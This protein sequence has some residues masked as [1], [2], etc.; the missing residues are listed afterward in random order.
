MTTDLTEQQLYSS[1]A[2]YHDLMRTRPP[3]ASDL[4]S[5]TVSTSFWKNHI[6]PLIDSVKDLLNRIFPP[7]HF[8]LP[9]FIP[10]VLT[11]LYYFAWGILI[12]CLVFL[13]WK[14]MG[15]LIN[16]VS[17][18]QADDRF[19]NPQAVQ[20]TLE[21]QISL[22]CKNKQFKKAMRLRWILFLE[23]CAYSFS[24]TPGELLSNI[25]KH[26]CS[27]FDPQ[28]QYQLMFGHAIATDET[29]AEYNQML[30]TIEK[31]CSEA[32]HESA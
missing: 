3:N 9:N 19:I 24:T 4:P 10:D 25:A 7:I 22:A 28:R 21:N 32:R 1:E 26:N 12:F 17:M 29:I 11:I 23:R 16:S 20:E 2:A 27:T 8:N 13:L 6:Q 15:T 18:Q 14:I 31:T 5:L 30:N